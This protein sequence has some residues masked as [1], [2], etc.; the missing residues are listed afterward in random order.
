MKNPLQN[1]YYHIPRSNAP[2]EKISQKT[3]R[4]GG[5]GGRGQ[6]VRSDNRFLRLAFE[7]V[8]FVSIYVCVDNK[9]I[10]LKYF[11]MVVV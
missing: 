5:R 8:T 7:A 10:L 4:R 6:P 1:G 11:D 9:K 2:L 3:D